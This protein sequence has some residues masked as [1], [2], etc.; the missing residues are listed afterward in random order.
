M[1]NKRYAFIPM[2]EGEVGPQK[3][4]KKSKHRRR[5]ENGKSSSH[6]DSRRKSHR[7]QSR[8]RSRSRSPRGD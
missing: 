8:S 4:E 1:S 5:D 7:T 2:D 3:V 6:R